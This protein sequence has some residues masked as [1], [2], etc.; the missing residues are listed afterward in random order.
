M[1][2]S[3]AARRSR[4][5]SSFLSFAAPQQSI[6][7]TRPA[8]N[9]LS[10]R[11]R[12]LWLGRVLIMVE[13]RSPRAQRTNCA[14]R[15]ISTRAV[16]ATRVWYFRDVNYTQN[17][18]VSDLRFRA[19]DIKTHPDPQHPPR[20]SAAILFVRRN[21]ASFTLHCTAPVCNERTGVCTLPHVQRV[22]RTKNANRPKALPCTRRFV[23]ACARCKPTCTHTP[24]PRGC[25]ACAL[26][27]WDCALILIPF[28]DRP[29]RSCRRNPSR[30]FSS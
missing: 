11:L 2:L 10:T 24:H 27:A 21:Y 26:L 5:G 18:A 6:N 17:S 7:L 4:P 25:A 20:Q 29:S 23:Q 14:Q 15:A 28:R 19:P 3:S 30:S 13:V 16:F 22:Q 1:V 9:I 8:L 12:R